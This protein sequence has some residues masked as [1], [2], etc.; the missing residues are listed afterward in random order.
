MAI[1]EG[2]S[3]QNAK[4]YS[5]I[6]GRFLKSYS[7]KDASVSDKKWLKTQLKE[8]MPELSEEEAEE[9][10][11][12]AIDAVAEFD[13]NI[14]SVNTSVESG[15][16]KEGWLT[17]KITESSVGV[18]VND[19]GNYIQNIDNAVNM[20]NTQMLRTI[21]NIDGNIS[22]SFNLDGFIA[23]QHHVNTFNMQ[24]VLDGG[25]Y[26]AKVCTPE[27]G[28]TYGLNSFD[29]VIK[30]QSSKT[31]HQY[32]M[33]FG[34]DAEAT[35]A[36]IKN[37]NYNNQR[38][39][40]APEQLDAVR[41][42]FPG[43]TIVSSIGGTESVKTLSKPLSKLE[44]KELQLNT[45][46]RGLPP[47]EDWNSFN[48]KEL[49]LNLGKNA[50][51]MGIQAAAITTGFDLA[52]RAMTGE[53]FDVEETV[54]LALKTGADTGIKAATAGALKVGV[55]KGI[56]SIIPK[57]TPIGVL[58]NIACLGIENIKIFGKVATGELTLIQALD[59]VGRTSTAMVY[60]LGWGTTGA[61]IG[62][63]VLSWIPIAGPILGGLAGGMIG[64][65]A[66]SKFGEAIY[67][68]AKKVCAIAKSV[69][70]AA[71]NGIKSAGSKL[72]DGIRNLK[73]IIFG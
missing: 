57:G 11:I 48:T 9:L 55:E 39:V 4:E 62:A 49:A 26:Y 65:M 64:Y 52:R 51:L 1:I 8:E 30:D 35:I 12:E 24:S 22:Q 6:L 37:G 45:Q 61:S 5:H 20:A 18:A 23:E 34:K 16:S 36:L 47:R 68:G 25:K 73:E 40:V 63:A 53:K 59:C 33:K 7:H 14:R 29:V 38:I 67:D 41:K 70:K 19:Y 13:E 21:T 2:L 32:Q 50:G 72:Y 28:Q 66:G 42:A 56:I 17:R 31:V 43:K 46:N 58:A 60:G 10:S 27:S 44:A 15:I 3:E 54:E 69:V 71:W